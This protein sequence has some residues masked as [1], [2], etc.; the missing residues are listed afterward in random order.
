M[1]IKF[2]NDTIKQVLLDGL[3]E[4]E[5]KLG[6]CLYS[7]ENRNEIGKKVG[8]EVLENDVPIAGVVGKIT[9]F[10]YLHISLLQVNEQYRKQKIGTQ[11]IKKM[12]QYAKENNLKAITLNTL[13]YQAKDF[14]L[15]LG[16]QI[17]G[18]FTDPTTNI[19]KYYFI[20]HLK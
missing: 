19:T 9:E 3:D 13:S 20:K 15:K 2:N 16:Y 8:Y 11:L 18:Q 17:F 6:I 7:G 14:Y 10:N 5:K 4:Q 12:E 1:E